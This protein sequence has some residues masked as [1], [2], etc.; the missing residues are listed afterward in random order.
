MKLTQEGIMKMGAAVIRSRAKYAE[1]VA[2]LE[3][4]GVPIRETMTEMI[5]KDGKNLDLI[6]I[7]TGINTHHT[8]MIE[9]SNAGFNCVLEKPPTSTIQYMDDMLAALKRN[10]TWCQVGFQSQSRK[11]TV[12]GLKRLI[13][14]G[15]LGRIREVAV[16]AT[17]QRAESYYARNP[18]AGKFKDG[19]VYVL[20]GTINNPLAHQVMNALYFSSMEWGKVAAPEWVRAELYKG[21]RIE[22]EDTAALEIGLKGGGKAYFL[23]TLCAEAGADSTV[24]IEVVGEKGKALWKTAGD[25]AVTYN[26]GRT[27]TIADVGRTGRDELFRNAARMV[28]GVD[29]QLNCALEMTRPFVLTVNAAFLSS[30]TTRRIPESMVKP[31]ITDNH[32]CYTDIVGINALVEKG[33]RERKLY[34]DLGAPWAVKTQPF[35][36]NGFTRFEM[37]TPSLDQK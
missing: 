36:L 29:K 33:W 26:D 24:H 7:P 19:D 27:E 18:W 32:E 25:A 5:E 37:A 17:W 11:D 21:H 35:S 12:M 23:G 20:D 31:R 9:A 34:S 15:K 16:R 4:A 22:S 3:K 2:E 8:L 10:K 30:G 13:C 6:A 14:D 28:R 1:Q